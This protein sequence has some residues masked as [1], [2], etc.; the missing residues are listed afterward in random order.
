MTLQEALKRVRYPLLEDYEGYWTDEE[1][2]TYL[3]EGNRIFHV[4]RGISQKWE[5][6]IPDDTT[7]VGIN[8]TA[9]NI[10]SLTYNGTPISATISNQTLHFSTPLKAGT[11][12]WIGDRPP[13]DVVNATDKFEINPAFEQAIIDYADYKAMLKD[14]DPRAT[15]FFSNFLMYKNAWE[16]YN[17]ADS[18]QIQQTKEW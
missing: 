2:T 14:N 8:L 13:K 16:Q 15:A 5:I 6:S 12:A 18:H 7:E 1:L 3:N 11:L 9:Q 10:R 4:N 17:Y